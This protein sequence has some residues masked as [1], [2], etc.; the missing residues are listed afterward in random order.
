MLAEENNGY[1]QRL[2]KLESD[3]A[4]LQLQLMRL[5]Q[6]LNKQSSIVD[7]NCYQIDQVDR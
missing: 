6:L 1:R 4:A 5:N 2:Q 3:N 7:I